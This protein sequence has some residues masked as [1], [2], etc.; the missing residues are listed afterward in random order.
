MMMTEARPSGAVRMRRLRGD[1]LKVV[2]VCRPR[3]ALSTPDVEIGQVSRPRAAPS[4]QSVATAA[5]TARTTATAATERAERDAE[6]EQPGR[7]HRAADERVDAGD[8]R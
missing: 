7:D 4:C 2:P 1:C 6:V 3:A 8:E 5:S